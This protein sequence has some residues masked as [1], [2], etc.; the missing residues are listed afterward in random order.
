MENSRSGPVR[1]RTRTTVLSTPGARDRA[2]AI[3]TAPPTA[4]EG[5]TALG[6]GCCGGSVS[7][8]SLSPPQWLSAH[9]QHVPLAP[10]L[11]PGVLPPLPAKPGLQG[12]PDG[13]HLGRCR[14]CCHRECSH[15]SRFLACAQS[16]RRSPCTPCF[17][18]RTLNMRKSPPPPTSRTT[19]T[20]LRMR[21]R[22]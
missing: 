19:S 11:H 15:K 20:G 17:G 22:R 2:P 1:I 12:E 8:S 5:R 9:Y 18:T 10:R 21:R 7:F 14:P 3:H 16:E 6:V 13:S 4:G